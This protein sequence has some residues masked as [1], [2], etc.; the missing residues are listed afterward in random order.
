M[1]KRKNK[2]PAFIPNKNWSLKIAEPG[3]RNKEESDKNRENQRKLMLNNK[4][5]KKLLFII[6]LLPVMAIG[7][8]NIG[9]AFDQFGSFVQTNMFI[10]WNKYIIDCNDLVADTI[11]QSGTVKCELVPIKMNGKIVSYNTVPIDTV[12]NKCECREY[13]HYASSL[14]EL[15]YGSNVSIGYVLASDRSWYSKP[16]PAKNIFSIKRDKICMIKK[17]KASFEDFFNRW[18]VEKKLIEFN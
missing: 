14:A 15:T 17:R 10:E 13:K 16:E 1:K 6:V 11:S 2:I 4:N 18:C 9:V 7:Q 3:T 12:W 8:N 5:M